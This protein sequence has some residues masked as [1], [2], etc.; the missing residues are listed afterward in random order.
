MADNDSLDGS[1]LPVQDTTAASEQAT[2]APKDVATP[3]AQP[4]PSPAPQ[5]PE[6]F[7]GKTTEEVIE[8]YQN[9]EKAH[10]RSNQELG[11]IRQKI[12]Q[13]ESYFSGLNQSGFD[14]NRYLQNQSSLPG[15][16]AKGKQQQDFN[17]RFYEDP[18]G[19]ISQAVLEGARTVL[20]E[21]E[22]KQLQKAQAAQSQRQQWM[23]NVA[24]AEINQLRF[25]N[26]DEW[27]DSIVDLM[28]RID[29]TDPEFARLANDPNLTEQS[30]RQGV[31]NLYDKA[32]KEKEKQIKDGMK[33]LG[34]D[35]EK[36][37]SIMASQKQAAANG[38]PG[39][40]ASTAGNQ[41]DQEAEAVVDFMKDRGW[42]H[43][44]SS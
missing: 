30:L 1:E 26:Q 17:E 10:G 14:A 24:D 39:N 32:L 31:R 37:K 27:D 22:Q 9:L 33:K 35:E 34:Y 40:K 38:A 21:H 16:E 41:G 6:K 13:Y 36:I 20:T 15:Q 25:E 18:Y 8:M 43:I 4:Q 5:L 3:E 28:K 12:N 29:S 2:E 23:G 19:T 7:Q 44:I 11:N 42:G